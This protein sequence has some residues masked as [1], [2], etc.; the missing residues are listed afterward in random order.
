MNTS[1]PKPAATTNRFTAVK[2]YIAGH[3]W[4]S[5]IILL[6]LIG[7]GYYAYKVFDAPSGATRYVTTVAATGTV[8]AS[9]SETGQVSASSN[10]SIESQ[11][12]GEVLSIPVQA[13]E[14]VSAGTALAYLDPT[15]A[16][17][18]VES[19]KQALE[20]AQLSL[21]MLQ[22]PTA[23]STLTSTQNSVATAQA[24]LVQAHQTSYNDISVAFLNLPTVITGLDSVLHGSTVP[25]RT[26]EQN[27]NA[28]SDMVEPYDSTVVQYRT[29]AESSYQTAYAAYTKTLADFK[30][31][32]RTADDATIEALIN[33]SYQTA[34]DISDA[35]KASTSFLNFV[36][37]TLTYHN[38]SLPSTLNGHLNTLT[39]YTTTTNQYVATL[40][41]DAANITSSERSLAAAQA[42]LQQLQAGADPLSVQSSQLSIQ[43]K[44]D[45]LAQAEQALAETVVRAPFDGTVAQTSVQQYQTIGNGTAVATMV[46]DNQNVNISVNE[47]DA[48]KLKVGQKATITF[49]ALP[50]ISIAG[51][52]SSV[53]SIGTVSSGV[54][55]YG[56]VVTFDTPNTSVKPGMSATVDIVTST[57]TGI[58]IPSSAVKTSGTQS[59][60]QI[61][62]PPL[63]NSSGSTGA[64]SAVAPTRKTVTTGLT[65]NTNIIIESGLSAGDQVV[66]KTIAGTATAAASTASRTTTTSLFGAGGGPGGVGGSAGAVRALTR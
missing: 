64:A 39:G 55:S 6:A 37:T 18:N 29:T 44:E 1:V 12:S 16:Q 14:H 19:A 15:T 28:Y 51:T 46:S 42:S 58:E 43:G 2:T 66:T 30:A 54:V 50:N 60:V 52:V 10:V 3:K 11:S 38:L 65:D 36:D 20:A 41:S 61:F 33:E 9:M 62:N 27:E 21:A 63:A 7:G 35:L 59:Y 13:G 56:A 4:L 49:D 5:G 31:T 57:E 23:T 47:V 32:P 24:N 53:N 34:A 8:V 17:Q 40:A 45:A 25:G 22:E 26:S 48:A